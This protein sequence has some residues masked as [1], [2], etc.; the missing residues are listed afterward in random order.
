MILDLCQHL[1]LRD[2]VI[3]DS[4]LNQTGLHILAGRAL[5]WSKG[6][7]SAADRLCEQTEAASYDRHRVDLEEDGARA[8]RDAVSA[9]VSTDPEV[10]EVRRSRDA[11]KTI[12]TFL[13]AVLKAAEGREKMLVQVSVNDRTEAQLNAK[14]E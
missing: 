6:K 7:L 9:R 4:I 14:D 3:R 11:A 8:T 13:Q 5:A 2:C 10:I 1:P 12:Y